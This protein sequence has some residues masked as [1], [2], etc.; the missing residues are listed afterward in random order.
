MGYKGDQRK[1]GSCP[2]IR[3]VMHFADERS[4]EKGGKVKQT[5]LSS[6]FSFFAPK[7]ENKESLRVLFEGL[8]LHQELLP[9]TFKVKERPV[10]SHR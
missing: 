4:M 3:N 10:Y 6:F 1:L 8:H 9:T 5:L 7:K 2:T